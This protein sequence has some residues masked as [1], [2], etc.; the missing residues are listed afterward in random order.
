MAKVDD[1]DQRDAIALV[2]AAQTALAAVRSIRSRL[3]DKRDATAPVGQLVAALLGA[4]GTVKEYSR[5]KLW[6]LRHGLGGETF[7]SKS[8]HAATSVLLAEIIAGLE[9]PRSRDEATRAATANDELEQIAK[10]LM[11]CD[12]NLDAQKTLEQLDQGNA[13]ARAAA[14]KLEHERRLTAAVAAPKVAPTSPPKAPPAGLPAGTFGEG[15]VPLEGAA[16]LGPPL[17]VG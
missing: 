14:H 7:A 6:S 11:R 16:D 5:A 13:L 4:G 12:M 15:D 17:T 10:L 3:T 8:P 2:R 9:E 1:L